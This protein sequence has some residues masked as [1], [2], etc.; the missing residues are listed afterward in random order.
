MYLHEEAVLKMMPF[1]AQ[2][3][4]LSSMYMWVKISYSR[5]FVGQMVISDEAKNSSISGNFV[6][7]KS[8]Q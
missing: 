1:L 2:T 7:K 4:W 6:R 8:N 5:W 3:L